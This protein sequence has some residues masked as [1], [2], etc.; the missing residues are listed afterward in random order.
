[1]YIP[2]HFRVED[3]ER[4]SALM[5]D[6]SFATLISHADTGPFA[7]H[8]PMLYRPDPSGATRGTLMAH[9]ARTNPQWQHFTP[10]REAL[11]IFHGPHTYISPSWYANIPAVPTWNYAVV[12]AYGHVSII[13]SHERVVALLRETMLA[14]EPEPAKP[15]EVLMPAEYRDR[16]MRGLV[17]FEMVLHRLEGKFKLSQNRSEADVRG[18]LEALSRSD[19]AEDRAMAEWMRR[20]HKLPAGT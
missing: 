7:S 19:T 11:A 4:L 17:A 20:E 9:M 16:L 5:R 12:H 6:Y 1:M 15:W 14:Y 3:I 10:E 2:D 13:E 8:L 18:V